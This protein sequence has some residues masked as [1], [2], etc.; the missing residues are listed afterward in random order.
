M[1]RVAE[2]L[3]DVR[4][5][6][7][8]FRKAGGAEDSGSCCGWQ[9]RLRG[10]G[11]EPGCALGVGQCKRGGGETLEAVESK[12]C[13]SADGRKR[14]GDGG[15]GLGLSKGR[16]FILEGRDRR[17]C[18]RCFGRCIRIGCVEP[19]RAR[20]NG[21]WTEE[22][23]CLDRGERVCIHAERGGRRSGV[24]IEM[25]WGQERSSPPFVCEIAFD[26]LALEGC[27][28]SGEDDQ[29]GQVGGDGALGR[30]GLAVDEEGTRDDRGR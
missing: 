26:G 27:K 6:N 24:D 14:R 7:G 15:A 21:H 29:F 10:V 22:M 18:R 13:E 8:A 5:F 16:A 4:L 28:R 1:D 19:D 2:K 3:V 9:I 30:R 25:G 23:V 12:S 17:A 20:G 11:C